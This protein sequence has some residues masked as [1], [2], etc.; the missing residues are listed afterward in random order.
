M[1][2]GFD[3]LGNPEDLTI[4]PVCVAMLAGPSLAGMLLTGSVYKRAGL[5][6]LLSGLVRWRVSAR[7]YMK[8]NA[9]LAGI[10]AR[11]FVGFF[12]ETGR[13]G[14]V[15]PEIWRRYSVLFTGV[16]GGCLVWVYD[17]T[18]SLWVGMITHMNLVAIQ[19]ILVATA[20]R[21]GQLDVYSRMGSCVVGYCYSG[22]RCP[23]P[24]N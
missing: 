12:E 24:A 7:W 18:A 4:P 19:F 6:E 3:E 9:L 8:V 15:V 17:R 2:V 5:R 1:A 22:Y 10:L 23:T 16:V 14:F 20:N 13:T 21:G 11:L